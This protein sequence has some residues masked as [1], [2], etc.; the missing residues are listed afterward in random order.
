MKTPDDTLNISKET[1][2]IEDDSYTRV[3][4]GGVVFTWNGVDYESP[5]GTH[6]QLTGIP[7]PQSVPSPPVKRGPNRKARRRALSIA[8]KG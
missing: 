1:F 8:R 6:I 7:R 3:R 4:I 5:S 2:Q